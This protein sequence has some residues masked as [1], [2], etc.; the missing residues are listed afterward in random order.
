LE[1]EDSTER[2]QLL[3]K[4]AALVQTVLAHRVGNIA[5]ALTPYGLDPLDPAR[6]LPP[7]V[8][9]LAA[10]T[11]A[12]KLAYQ[13]CQYASLLDQLPALLTAAGSALD[14]ASDDNGAV[15]NAIRANAYQVVGSLMLKLGDTALAAIAADRS[16]TSAVASQNPL[17]IGSSAR[18]VTHSLMSS[19]HDVR[20][21]EIATSAAHRLDAA[22]P[23]QSPQ[24]LSVYGALI[25]RGAIAAARCE[26]RATASQL[27]DEADATAKR[28]GRDGN[29]EWTA[30]G[31]TNVL[32]HRVNVAVLLGDAGAAIDLASRINTT[33]ITVAERRAALHVDIA[34][35]YAQWG[36]LELSLRSLIEAELTADEDLQSRSS[37]HQLLADLAQRGSRRMSGEAIALATRIGI[38][39]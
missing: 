6:H 36:K 4:V 24:S 37:V 30:F 2:R 10:M 23:Q 13:A 15:A 32:L 7:T 3:D 1:G 33:R 26:D 34:H 31:P 22:Q 20:A 11:S 38:R 16:M 25:L 9:E 14:D 29:A 28:L 12:A 27:L 8:A 35:A 19:G 18:I 39:I 21:V 17:A 5:R